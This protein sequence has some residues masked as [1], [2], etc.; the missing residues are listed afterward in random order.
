MNLQ[1]HMGLTGRFTF[2]VTRQNGEKEVVADFPNLILDS[3]LNQMVTLS[4]FTLLAA[5][6]V[7]SGSTAPAVGQTL[8]ANQVAGTTATQGSNLLDGRGEAVPYLGWEYTK[9]FSTGVAA[10]NLSEVGMGPYASA[11]SSLFS[12]A[13][14]VDSG[15][16]PTTITVLP[17]E[18]LDVTYTLKMYLGVAPVVSTHTVSGVPTTVTIL[19]ANG[20]TS[21]WAP[22]EFSTYPMWAPVGV[23]TAFRY[24]TITNL[25]SWTSSITGTTGTAGTWSSSGTYAGAVGTKRITNSVGTPTGAIAGLILGLGQQSNGAARAPFKV[26][27]EPPISMLASQQLAVT[28]TT[29]FGRYTP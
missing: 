19:P 15:G 25:G 23:G 2:T 9:R 3:G 24:T 17:S 26:Q 14:I 5:C 4:I 18:I 16:N 21:A 13:L 29:T 6:R 1:Q 7:G 22:S 28:V 27:F 20:L 11:T 12:R 8:L 10:G